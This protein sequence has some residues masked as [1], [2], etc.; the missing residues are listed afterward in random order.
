MTLVLA[1]QARNSKNATAL[2]ETDLLLTVSC[3]TFVMQLPDPGI[4]FG[5]AH[6]K[7]PLWTFLSAAGF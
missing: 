6:N 7:T 4:F 3:S 2:K 1:V 5:L